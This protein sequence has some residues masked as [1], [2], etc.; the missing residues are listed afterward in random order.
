M[1]LELLSIRFCK[2]LPEAFYSR[3][4]ELT[5]ANMGKYVPVTPILKITDSEGNILY[6]LDRE[7]LLQNE[8]QVIQPE[9]A[10]QLILILTDNEAPSMNF[11]HNNLF[12]NTQTQL[13]RPAAAKSGT[14]NIFRNIWIIGFTTDVS[15][16]VRLG[17]CA[18]SRGFNTP[19][20][21]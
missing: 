21:G 9:I 4:A 19:V 2:R 5:V 17:T 18:T 12:G 3:L 8:E 7:H 13:G 16:S 6:E 14:T 20:A 15:I 11:T 1:I 10:Y